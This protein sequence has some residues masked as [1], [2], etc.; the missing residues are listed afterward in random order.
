[1]KKFLKFLFCTFSLVAA[2]FGVYYLV[3]NVINKDESEDDFDDLDDDFDEFETEKDG[4]ASD[5]RE[6]VPIN[7]SG[8][9][10]EAKEETPAHY[11]ADES[12]ESK[13]DE[14]ETQE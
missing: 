13:S 9:D 1:M 14:A 4:N 12:E 6:Y 5:S 3:K 2:A 8:S 10:D 7:L 11:E